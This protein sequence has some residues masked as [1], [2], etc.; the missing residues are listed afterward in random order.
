MAK[1]RVNKKGKRV[2]GVWKPKVKLHAH[3]KT[4]KDGEQRT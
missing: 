3:L 2:K 1:V 4:T